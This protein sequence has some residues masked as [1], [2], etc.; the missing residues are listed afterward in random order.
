MSRFPRN[1]Y[2]VIAIDAPWAKAET[3]PEVMNEIIGLPPGT[4]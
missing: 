4:M 2:G 3:H 1:Q